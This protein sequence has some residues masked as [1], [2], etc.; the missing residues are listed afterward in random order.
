MLKKLI[1]VLKK[2]IVTM[3]FPDEI[4]RDIPNYE[5]RYKISSY[6]RVR[7]MK[8]TVDHGLV[9]GYT[10]QERVLK[11]STENGYARVF[12]YGKENVER[13]YVHK[14]VAD[15]FFDVPIAYRDVMRYVWHRDG[16]RL[17]NAVT[18]LSIRPVR[19]SPR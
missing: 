7:S 5:G 4:W 17:N 12:L 1:N 13:V 19:R 14:V 11:P 18:N 8:R 3:K 6:G 9:K 10:I 2:I 15:V 16:D